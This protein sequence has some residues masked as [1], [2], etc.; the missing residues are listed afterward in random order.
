LLFL[1]IDDRCTNIVLKVWLHLNN[2]TFAFS[3]SLT[4]TNSRLMLHLPKDNATFIHFYIIHDIFYFT[5]VTFVFRLITTASQACLKT[6]HLL[7]HVHLVHVYS[8]I[9]SFVR[10]FVTK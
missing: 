10:S 3:Q 8:F 6:A 9:Y 7:V 2:V 4:I 5:N 1:A